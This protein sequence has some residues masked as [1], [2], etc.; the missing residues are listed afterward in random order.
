MQEA[1]LLYSPQLMNEVTDDTSP[2]LSWVRALVDFFGDHFAQPG[3][4]CEPL[5]GGAGYRMPAQ[6]NSTGLLADAHLTRRDNTWPL[7]ESQLVLKGELSFEHIVLAEVRS[8][9]ACASFLHVNNI[10]RLAQV[11]RVR[12]R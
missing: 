3:L 5:A 6:L 4:F 11:V 12:L 7:A 2:M 8:A 10:C 1:D 9:V